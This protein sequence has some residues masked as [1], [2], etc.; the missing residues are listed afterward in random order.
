MS[1]FVSDSQRGDAGARAAA[2]SR[3]ARRARARWR[4][5]GV[6]R[7]P[8]TASSRSTVSKGTS[9]PHDRQVHAEGAA[10]QSAGRLRGRQP[11]AHRAR[12]SRHGQRAR[13]HAA[14]RRRPALRSV[15]VVQAGNRTRVVFNLNKPQTFETQVDGNAV[16]VTLYD[17]SGHARRRRTQTVQRFAEAQPGDIAARAARRRLPPRRATAKAASSS[18][19]PTTDRHRHPPAGPDADRRLPQDVAAAQ[20]RAPARRAATSARR[21]VTVDTFEQGGNARMVI[22]PKG[23]WEHSAYQTDNQFILEVKPVQEDPNKLSQGTRRATRARSSRSTSRT[24]KCAR[25]CR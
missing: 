1:A 21:C 2:R 9:G 20:P 14:G 25:C 22:E 16:L 8:P 10:R 23:L 17:Q 6:A 15:N 5:R 4:R 7:R 3:A 11:A 24:S 12:L 13:P 18:T 19:C